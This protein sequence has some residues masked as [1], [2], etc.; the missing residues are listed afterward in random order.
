VPGICRPAAAVLVFGAFATAI[1]VFLDEAI[2][3][4]E[5]IGALI[6]GA[7]LLFIDDRV[8]NRFAAKQSPAD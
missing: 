5:I 4:K 6:I 8:I 3:A 1:I 2:E 7:G